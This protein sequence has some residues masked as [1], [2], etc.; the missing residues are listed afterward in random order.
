MSYATL[1]HLD[2]LGFHR[3]EHIVLNPS[4]WNSCS[5]KY[6]VSVEM[7]DAQQISGV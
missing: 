3:L 1:K 2:E 7:G 6:C 4:V 5:A